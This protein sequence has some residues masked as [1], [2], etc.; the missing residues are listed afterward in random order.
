[1][2]LTT[3]DK[4]E[5]FHRLHSE[6][7]ILILINAWDAASARIIEEA[8]SQAIA[9]TSA[10]MAWALGYSDGEQV[11]LRE[12]LEACARICRVVTT[13]VS[14][15]IEQGYGKTPDEVAATVRS[16]LELGV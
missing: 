7:R 6:N 9:T 4:A 5:A 16:L 2:R 8:G 15:D 12:L 1:M 11:G 3:Q 14:V 13:P 10:G